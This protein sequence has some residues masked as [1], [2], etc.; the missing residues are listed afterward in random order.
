MES[1]L[2]LAV[3]LA[4]I[5]FLNKNYANIKGR[6]GEKHVAKILERLNPQEYI[7]L[8]DLYI[9][10]EDGTTTQI[11][12]ILITKTGLFVIE[13]K[14]YNGWILGTENSQYWTQ[15]IY[16]RNEKF[17]NPIWQNSGHIKSLKAYLGDIIEDISVHSVIVF[18]KQATLKFNEPFKKAKVI[19]SN[20]LLAV[21]KGDFNSEVL[22]NFKIEEIKQ[23]L[24]SLYL[25]ERKAQKQQSKKH[26]SDIKK[27]NSYRNEQIK[28]NICPRCGGELITRE[29]KFGKFIGCSRYPKCRFTK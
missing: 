14:N 23:R 6:V 7:L 19:K 29:G 13:T 25:Q 4:A 1:Y 20:E 26:I 17:Y 9:P 3:M 16:K 12:H 18:G 15:V 24:S 21:V 11:D 8:N 2:F 5:W 10:K 28:Q 22:T 27:K